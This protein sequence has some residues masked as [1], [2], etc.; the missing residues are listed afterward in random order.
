MTQVFYTVDD[1]IKLDTFTLQRGCIRFIYSCKHHRHYVKLNMHASGYMGF[2]GSTIH[3]AVYDVP[4]WQIGG[5]LSIIW[6]LVIVR[7]APPWTIL[8]CCVCR[9]TRYSRKLLFCS[10]PPKTTL[11]KP[12]FITNCRSSFTCKDRGILHARGTHLRV[13]RRENC[14]QNSSQ[15]TSG[16]PFVTP[17]K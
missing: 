12:L 16:P 3:R 9:M 14:L 2:M 1:K 11:D 13:I 15:T 4:R 5:A 6:S 8:G 7:K 10:G 17:R